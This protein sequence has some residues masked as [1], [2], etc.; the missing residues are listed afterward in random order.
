MG[1]YILFG[2]GVWGGGGVAKKAEWWGGVEG[3][4]CANNYQ[5]LWVDVQGE[6]LLMPSSV[7]LQH[8][9]T[10]T[11]LHAQGPRCAHG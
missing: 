10:H 8:P 6:P 5:L 9:G 1:R 7:V 2:G 4:L 3:A 11:S